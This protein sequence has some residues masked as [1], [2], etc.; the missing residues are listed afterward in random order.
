VSALVAALVAL[1]AATPDAREQSF[2]EILRTYPSRPPAE[3]TA[4]A[5]RLVDDGPFAERDRA[6]YWVASVR[7]NARD[8][9]GARELFAR[10]RSEH[11]SSSWIDRADLGEAQAALLEHRFGA[12]LEWL[13]RAGKSADAAV[14]ELARISSAQALQMRERQT[15]AF[16]A[17]A[18]ALIVA[19]FFAAS[20]ARHRP[21]KILPLPSE[22]SV[23]LPVLALVALLSLRQD[24]APR[25]AVLEICASGALLAALSG[26]RVRAA[27]PRPLER[28]LQVSAALAALSACAYVAVYRA[29]LIGMVLETFRAGPE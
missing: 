24:P 14:R 29:D 4:M 25:A 7:L 21:V 16:V 15:W 17:G 19:A 23:L 8:L 12:A 27:G 11:P 1:A 5:L 18:F 20:I 10:L 26:L 28:A 13:E 6:L 22:V 3:S 2:L 9:G